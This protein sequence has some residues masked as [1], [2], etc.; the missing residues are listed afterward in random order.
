MQSVLAQE[1]P[2]P[3]Q[4]GNIDREERMG[5]KWIAHAHVSRNGA[6]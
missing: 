6:T 5:E 2:A 4:Q 3:D 1:E